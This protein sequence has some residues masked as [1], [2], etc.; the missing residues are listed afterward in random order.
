MMERS[1]WSMSYSWR[2][3]WLTGVEWCAP[4]NNTVCWQSSAWTGW[5]ECPLRVWNQ[6]SRLRVLPLN[7]SEHSL[8]W[9]LMM[10]GSKIFD[11]AGFSQNC[12]LR[13]FHKKPL[14]GVTAL[15][16]QFPSHFFSNSLRLQLSVCV[17]VWIDKEAANG[18]R[19]HCVFTNSV[20]M[21]PHKPVHSLVLW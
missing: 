20:N 17:G 3:R 13:F 9:S 21:W 6:G 7:T 1:G 11:Q 19:Q 4:H 5:V 12:V 2:Q 18:H 15:L 8:L 10:S 14:C 16:I